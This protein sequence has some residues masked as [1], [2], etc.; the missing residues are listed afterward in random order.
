MMQQ[1]KN[2]LKTPLQDENVLYQKISKEFC[3]HNNDFF[4]GDLLIAAYKKYPHHVALECQ[5]SKISYRELLF[6]ASLLSKTFIRYGITK[7]DRIV[8]HLE[9]SI[10]FYIAYFATWLCGSV[11][12]PLN[13]FLHEKE[14]AYII[15]DANPK[16]IFS[17]EDNQTKLAELVNQAL[18]QT[19]PTILTKQE[20]D[21]QT[22]VPETIDCSFFQRL[23]YEE[24]CLF[25]YTSG[26]SGK[27]KGVMLSSRNIATNTIQ[28]F[29][30]FKKFGLGTDERFFCVLPLFHVFAQNTCI[31]LPTMTGGT[32]IIVPKIDRKLI[33]EGLTKKPTLF[34]GFPALYG[35]LCLMKTAPLDTIKFFI[36]G[37]DML[38]DKIR[39]AFAKIYGRKICSGYGL[40]E[41]SP[42][43]AVNMDNNECAT[44]VVGDPLV[45]ITCDIRDDQGHSLPALSIGTLWIKGDNV[46]MGYYNAP[47]MTSAVLQ[48]GWLCTG[49]LA[50]RDS[51]GIIAITGRSKDLIIHK[52][53][54]IYPQEV[55]N[56]LLTHPAI[57]KAA[58]VGR[59]DATSGQVPV[60]FVAI[61]PGNDE[62]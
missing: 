24:A 59:D 23:G 58:V 9:N 45:G 31:W 43:V 12:I 44:N 38:P 21:W 39:S 26:T 33:F 29:A 56:V 40:T 36:S 52:G 15:D 42:V 60:A 37:A 13:T 48:D 27:P 17:T 19:L 55:E 8:V 3:V 28:A 25:L 61:K 2:F 62:A 5:D 57:F 53:F 11:A 50:S 54:N 46:M 4:A 1:L 7:N 49:D 6:R 41:A 22:P 47:E 51:H 14:L 30:R 32:V 10:E 18:I 20:I 34:L 16:L 35:L